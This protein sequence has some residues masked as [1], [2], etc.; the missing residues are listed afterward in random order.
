MDDDC[1]LQRRSF[2]P[3]VLRGII[4]WGVR[5]FQIPIMTIPASFPAFSDNPFGFL[6][7]RTALIHE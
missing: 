6:K 7:T 4:V 1:L 5:I 2:L 3:R